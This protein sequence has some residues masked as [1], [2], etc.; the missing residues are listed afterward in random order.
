MD[1]CTSTAHT[2]WVLRHTA[3]AV[4]KGVC[5]GAT[6]VELRE[7]FP[8]E[9][10]AIRE[11]LEGMQPDA[12]F[13]SPLSRATRL[14]EALGF[15]AIIE[16]RL[17]EQSFGAWEMQRYDEIRDPQLQAWYEDYIHIAPT[18]GESFWTVVQRVGTFI[19][20]LRLRPYQNT[21]VVAHGGIQ[22]AVGAYLGLYPLRDAPQHY[23]T[24]GS[25]LHY[26]L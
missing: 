15:D 19:E 16:P 5:Y 21:L 8:E 26:T 23:G 12:I 1:M 2:L 25:L 14:A 17:R 9:V 3:V 4:P 6:D 11:S 24:Y 13:S 10:E 18:A 22:M 7:T 20:E